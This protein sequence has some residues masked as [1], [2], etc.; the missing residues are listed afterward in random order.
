MRET[1]GATERKLFQQEQWGKNSQSTAANDGYPYSTDYLIGEDGDI[2]EGVADSHIAIKGHDQQ[3]RRFHKG[4]SM[5]EE[6]LG[7]T[8]L[9]A[10]L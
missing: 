3:H 6:E 7:K 9:K 4:E 10:D 8:S 5:E 2:M 1:V